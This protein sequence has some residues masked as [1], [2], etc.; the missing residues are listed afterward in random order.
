MNELDKIIYEYLIS[1]DAQLLLKTNSIISN[2]EFTYKLS[3]KIMTKFKLEQKI[4]RY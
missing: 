4:Y 1:D 3:E 2:E